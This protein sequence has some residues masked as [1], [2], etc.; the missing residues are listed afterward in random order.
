MKSLVGERRPVEAAVPKGATAFLALEALLKADPCAYASL[1]AGQKAESY[2]DALR[3]S[4]FFNAWGL[5]CYKLT[6]TT[7]SLKALGD[8]AVAALKP[9][10]TG[11]Q[12]APLSGSQEATTSRACGNRVC[13][14]AWALINEFK[15]R[16]YTYSRDPH[17]HDR[18]IETLLRELEGHAE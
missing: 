10:L 6:E 18:A 11:R 3:T 16:P 12:A 9:L 1:P 17:E 15:R 8:E 7:H 5:P 2:V 4:V 13:D 14:C